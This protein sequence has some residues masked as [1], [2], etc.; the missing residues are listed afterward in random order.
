MTDATRAA[1]EVL[2][3]ARE[4]AAA[5]AAGDSSRLTALLHP[6]FRWVSH[7]GDRFT[8]EEYVERN[9][10][11]PLAWRSQALEEPEVTVVGE[12]AVLHAVVRDVVAT[13]SGDEEFRMPVTQ[14]WV[15]SGDGWVCLAGHAGPRLEA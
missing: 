6:S 11:G 12:T 4:R 14:V 5:L 1:R 3:A 13:E 2:A 9:T 7:R 8:R 10:R 15:R